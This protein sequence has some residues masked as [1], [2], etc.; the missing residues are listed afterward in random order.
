MGYL[1]KEMF[2]KPVFKAWNPERASM[3]NGE[4]ARKLS[5]GRLSFLS[6]S[7]QT[8]SSYCQL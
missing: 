2:G 7:L 8:A 6:S 5:L 3:D 4:E 1:G